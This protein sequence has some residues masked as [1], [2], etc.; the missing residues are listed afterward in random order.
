M[1]FEEYLIKHRLGVVEF[2]RLMKVTHQAVSN[3]KKGRRPD[4]LY[5]NKI[6]KRTKGE[7]S[8]EDLGW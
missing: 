2:S 5:A 1:R 3:W 8:L 6:V 4:R 7:V